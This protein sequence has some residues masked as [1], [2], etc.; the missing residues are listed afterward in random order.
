MYVH[1]G[2]GGCRDWAW[3]LWCALGLWL[4]CGFPAACYLWLCLSAAGATTFG[5]KLKGRGITV[6]RGVNVG[7]SLVT[8]MLR[9]SLVRSDT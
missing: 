5:T 2:Q 6:V 1:R 4:E 8:T 9:A 7:V 3:W